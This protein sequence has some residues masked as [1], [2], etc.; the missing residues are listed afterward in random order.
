MRLQQTRQHIGIQYQTQKSNNIHLQPHQRNIHKVMTSS[1]KQ[2]ENEMDG[3]G[4]MD[5][6]RGIL[7]KGADAAKWAW[8]NRENIKTGL[9]MAKGAYSS[10]IGTSIRN[11]LPYKS[12]ETFRPGYAGEKHAILQLP[13]GKYGVANFMGPGTQV[14]K[15]LKRGDPPRTA[16][17]KVAMRHDIDYALAK[18]LKTKEKQIKAIRGADN[19]MVA[20]LNRIAAN[21]GDAQKNIFQGRRLI[22]AKMVGEDYGLMKKGSFGGDLQPISNDDKILLMSKRAGL[23]QEGYGILP[24]QAL[25][26]KLIKNM[27]KKGKGLKLPGTSG[28]GL[29][30]GGGGKM[31]LHRTMKITGQKGG[32]IFAALAALGGL[33]AEAVSGVTV[34][35]VG[36]AIAT[37]A[38]SATGAVVAKKI[39]GS[40]KMKGKGAQDV[41]KKI[42]QKI[43]LHKEKVIKAAESIGVKESDIPAPIREKAKK[44]LDLIK[45]S[46]KPDKNKLVK[47]AKMLIP[48]IRHIFHNKLKEKVKS[49]L[50]LAGNGLSGFDEKVLAIVKKNL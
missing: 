29:N 13:N 30:P 42:A 34:A 33:I 40:G 48:H 22:Q 45:K 20:S 43:A 7:S 14:V 25:K 1:Y 37:G 36:S 31:K 17:D 5:M 39:L 44:A 19:R 15:R 27:R 16:S 35:S 18:G 38:A 46:G 28:G 24:G 9:K 47:V 21:N 2:D 50:P 4:L 10:E 11:N 32:F 3:E 6:A 12:D 41:V 26:Q 49:A 8:K 23:A